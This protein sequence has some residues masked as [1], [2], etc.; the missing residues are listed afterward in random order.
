M[1]PVMK[2]QSG[3]TLYALLEGLIDTSS[4]LPVADVVVDG[5]T[6]DSRDIGDNYLF[7]AVRGTASHGL[8]FAEQAVRSGASVVLWDAADSDQVKKVDAL[9]NEIICVQVEGLQHK[10]GEIASRFFNHP[11]HDLNLIG[12]TGT[13][14][15]TSVSHYIAQCM[16]SKLSPC[17]VLG[18]LGNGMIHDLKP[19]G[20][21]T[22]SAV[23]VSKLWPG[24]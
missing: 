2:Q 9:S 16:D 6:Q 18:T 24:W 7:I 11:S 14:G 15:K 10:T 17:G 21:T 22:A 13:D 1:M 5:V 4:L 12:V 19:T 23:H 8:G 20:L 3:I